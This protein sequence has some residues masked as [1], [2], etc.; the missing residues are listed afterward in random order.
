MKRNAYKSYV[1][2]QPDI[3]SVT[4]THTGVIALYAMGFLCSRSKLK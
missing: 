3:S 2:E 1:T 4:N